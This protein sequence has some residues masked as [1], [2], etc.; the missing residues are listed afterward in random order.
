MA[1][2]TEV[3]DPKHTTAYLSKVGGHVTVNGT[4]YAVGLMWAP[5]QNPDDPIPEIREAMDAEPGADLYCQRT[6]SAPQYGLG[7]S[8]LGHLWQRPC[9]VRLLCAGCS[10]W[11]KDGG[12]WPSGTI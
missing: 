3:F 9:R 12:L 4:K 11:M 1:D 8:S 2:E 7:K 10:R 5:L 6:S